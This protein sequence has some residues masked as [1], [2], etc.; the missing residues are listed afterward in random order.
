MREK[1]MPG[2]QGAL[3]ELHRRCG[4]KLMAAAAA[5]AGTTGAAAVSGGQGHRGFHRK[6]H[7]GQVNFDPLH[8]GQQVF[9]DAEGKTALFLSLILII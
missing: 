9:V 2:D 5:G 6:A 7:I 1:R 8:L 3:T 4:L